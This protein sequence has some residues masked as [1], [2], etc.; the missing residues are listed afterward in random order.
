MPRCSN[1]ESYVSSDY[2][3]VFSEDG[4]G[5]AACPRCP[6]MVRTGSEIREARGSRVSARGVDE[7]DIAND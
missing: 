7:G 3:R 5:V 2:V 6:D 1:C 4:E